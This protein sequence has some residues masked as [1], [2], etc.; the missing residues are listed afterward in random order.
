MCDCFCV[1]GVFLCGCFLYECEGV[2][3]RGSLCV[4]E[5]QTI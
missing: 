4:N 5:V 1:S 2:Q 3:V